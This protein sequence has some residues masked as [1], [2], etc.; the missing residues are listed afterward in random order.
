MTSGRDG[1]HRRLAY[2]ITL[3][4]RSTF[5]PDGKSEER[6]GEMESLKGIYEG[7]SGEN[8]SVGVGMGVGMGVW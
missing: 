7:F 1:W 6:G 8:N 5:T 3:C 4:T 2:W